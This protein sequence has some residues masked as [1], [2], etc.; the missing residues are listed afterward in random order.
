MRN[1]DGEINEF[2]KLN[3]IEKLLEKYRE[4]ESF[5]DF[6]ILENKKQYRRAREEPKLA[7]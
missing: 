7:K 6:T 2:K 4:H 1:T 3:I 5:K